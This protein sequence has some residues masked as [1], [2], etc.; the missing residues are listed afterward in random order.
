MKRLLPFALFGALSLPFSTAHALFGG[1]SSAEL[2]KEFNERFEPLSRGQLDL[3]NQNEEL[4]SEVA[5]LRG[6]IE[7]LT[8]ELEQLK[9]RQRDFYVDLDNRLRRIEDP[10]SAVSSDPSSSGATPQAAL[11]EAEARDYEA[12][13]NLLKEGKNAEALAAFEK[14]IT[15]HLTSKLLPN[16]NFW[17][18]NAALQAK[19]VASARNYFSAVITNWPDDPVAPDAMLGLANS[20]QALGEARLSQETLSNIILRYPGSSAAQVASQRLGS[21]PRR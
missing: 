6:Q 1:D 21:A 13:L 20:Q 3:V 14:F 4:R 8:Y 5:K 2:R 11:P 17:A 9:Q 12:A 15:H 10:S 16:A 19:E 18:G 7:V